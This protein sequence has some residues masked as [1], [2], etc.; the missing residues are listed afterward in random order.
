MGYRKLPFGYK[1]VMGEVTQAP[2]EAALVKHIFDQYLAGTSFKALTME[3]TLQ[4]IP[5]DDEKPWNKNQIARILEDPRYIGEKGFPPIISPETHQAA[6]ARR[7]AMR[8]PRQGTT[9]S[10]AVRKLVGRKTSE[11]PDEQIMAILNSL[12]LDPSQIQAPSFHAEKTSADLRRRLDEVL[13]QLPVDEDKA[14]GL[15]W[16]CAVASYQT[17][18]P[19][20]YETERIRYLAAHAMPMEQLDGEFLRSVASE[21]MIGDDGSVSLRLKNQQIIKGVDIHE[22]A[23]GKGCLPC[24]ASE[25]ETFT[26]SNRR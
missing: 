2:E 21:V 23:E 19:N 25:T 1:M 14:K 20:E 18:D 11:D 17:I 9:Q 13:L 10:K 7:D 4:P 15:I 22:S 8:K 3:M 24:R 12:I 5:F 26:D 16:D 6:Q